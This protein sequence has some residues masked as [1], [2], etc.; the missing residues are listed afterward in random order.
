MKRKR[1]TPE[2]IIGWQGMLSPGDIRTNLLSLA[3]TVWWNENQPGQA[4]ERT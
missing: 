2:K 1:F 4:H 3:K